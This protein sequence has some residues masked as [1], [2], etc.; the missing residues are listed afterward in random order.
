M[1]NNIYED[2]V[3]GFLVVLALAWVLIVETCFYIWFRA[4]LKR[5]QAVKP[6]III[7]YDEIT[8]CALGAVNYDSVQN[9]F[10][11]WFQ[12]PDE[13]PRNYTRSNVEEV[14]CTGFLGKEVRDAN[15]ADREWLN[16]LIQVLQDD[17]G[18]TLSTKKNDFRC[19]RYMIDP[20][21]ASF[22]P[23]LVYLSVMMLTSF[24]GIVLRWMGF[25]R[26]TSLHG[27]KYWYKETE[28]SETATPLLDS[29]KSMVFFH[30][31][32]CGLTP[33]LPTIAQLKHERQFLF[34]SPW[35]SYNPWVLPVPSRLFVDAVEMAMKIHGAQ[36]ATVV[37]HSFGSV[38]AT[39]LLRQ[40]P[41]L[42]H[43][44]VLVDP[45][46]ILLCLPDVCKN[47]LYRNP[48]TL[49]GKLF[50]YLG[51]HE[52][53]ISRTFRRHLVSWE[54]V[55][56]PDKIPP[57]SNV[58]LSEL[59]HIVPSMSLYNALREPSV[60]KKV[61]THLVERMPHGMLLFFPSQV[62]LMVNSINNEQH[63]VADGR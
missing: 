31:V 53:G 49:F 62:R 60:T 58:M 45:V 27:V 6:P 8:K 20:V 9:I 39:W 28:S 13:V 17:H 35:V 18:L 34:E 14:L 43:R 33:Y 32:G 51:S 21:V 41:E 26:Y 12:R 61:T 54:S 5:S 30:G 25:Q 50:D 40:K 46:A 24:T 22:R 10:A 48:T 59:D 11:G 44:M 23:L 16:K 15:G 57:N 36:K 42:V 7:N 52:F 37:G 55:L 4:E 1:D 2:N 38:Q 29:S 56:F 3:L 19:M 47:F 63:F